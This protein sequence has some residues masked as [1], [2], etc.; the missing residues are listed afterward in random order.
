MLMLGDHFELGF[1]SGALSF[2]RVLCVR[3]TSDLNLARTEST[4]ITILTRQPP[5]KPIRDSM[6]EENML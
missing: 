4:I 5:P 2:P 3:V 1:D 6:S